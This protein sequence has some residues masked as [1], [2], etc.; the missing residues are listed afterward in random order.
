MHL[1]LPVLSLPITTKVLS[2]N[3]TQVVVHSIQHYSITFVTG[4]WFSP[5]TPITSYVKIVDW[6]DLIWFIM[7]NATFSNI[8]A[9]SWR[10]RNPEYPERTTDHGQ[11]TGKLYH[12]R[13]RVEWFSPGTPMTSYPGTLHP[14]LLIHSSWNITLLYSKLSTPL[15]QRLTLM[16]LLIQ[17]VK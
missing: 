12:L 5:D 10:P 3:P 8:S 16:S 4:R 13:L 14:K 9:I 7:L 15:I 2:S 6:F 11:A 17:T 1:Q